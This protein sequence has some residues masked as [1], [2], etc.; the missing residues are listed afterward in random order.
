[1]WH[2]GDTREVHRGFW[3]GRPEGKRQLGKLGVNGSTILKWIFR[4]GDRVYGLD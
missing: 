2:V 4:K 1:M 3:G